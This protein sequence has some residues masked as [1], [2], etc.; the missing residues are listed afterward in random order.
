M[1][2][3][4]TPNMARSVSK[5]DL[6][7]IKAESER[8]DIY[9]I[10]SPS[11]KKYVGKTH[12]AV[13]TDKNKYLWG[14]ME[15]W[16]SHVQAALAYNKTGED[17]DGCRRLNEEIRKYKD[18]LKTFNVEVLEIVNE[19]ES[20]SYEI[21]WIEKL[22]TQYEVNPEGGLNIFKG[23]NGGG[24]R[25][26]ET[27][28][29]QSESIKRQHQQ[30]TP[31]AYDTFRTDENREYAAKLQ[32]E[33]RICIHHD[34]IT[35]LPYE[36]QFKQWGKDK[37][38]LNKD[39][40]I[41]YRVTTPTG[42]QT[43]VVTVSRKFTLQ[44]LD[45]LF[46]KALDKFVEIYPTRVNEVQHFYGL[47]TE[48]KYNMDILEKNWYTPPSK[49]E[50]QEPKNRYKNKDYAKS[51]KR[52]TQIQKNH[53]S[54]V[55]HNGNI[56]PLSVAP[57][58]SKTKTRYCTGYEV[59]FHPLLKRAKFHDKDL[60]KALEKALAYALEVNPDHFVDEPLVTYDIHIYTLPVPKDMVMKFIESKGYA[61]NVFRPEQNYTV[62]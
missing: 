45:H 36:L 46:E 7:L 23:G 62:V 4:T 60:N 54:K 26:Q 40:Q 52:F 21:L 49:Q 34:N 27:R 18:P 43:K 33:K 59:K 37:N 15:R 57:Y 38:D 48:G 41:G 12:R 56:L 55:D 25:P 24:T 50:G 42:K 32:R 14:A 16:K 53:M 19:N 58:G 8:A 9:L 22:R 28:E 10:T 30:R 13:Y 47:T 1:P 5:K 11:G 35:K 20:G 17:G 51:H 61:F 31:D 29:R 39:F 6:A 2:Q 44:T 3:S